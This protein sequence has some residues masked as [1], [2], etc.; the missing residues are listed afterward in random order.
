MNSYSI[1]GSPKCRLH[2]AENAVWQWLAAASSL[3]N[4]RIDLR[5]RVSTLSANLPPENRLGLNRL[6]FLLE[7]TL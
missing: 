7:L 6:I 1:E 2:F 5:S 4:G 3:V